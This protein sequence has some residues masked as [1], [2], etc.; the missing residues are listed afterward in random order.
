MKNEIMRERASER[1]WESVSSVFSALDS[2]S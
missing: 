1:D 2:I